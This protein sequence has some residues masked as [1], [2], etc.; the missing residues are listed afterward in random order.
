MTRYLF[1]DMW[2]VGEQIARAQA[3][4]F[5]MEFDGALAP[6]M[7]D[8][9]LISLS[10]Q[11]QRVLWSLAGQE[12]CKLAF[13]SYRSRFE[14]QMRVGLPDVW[15]VGCHGLEISGPGHVSVHPAAAVYSRQLQPVASRIEELLRPIPELS[16][17]D[18]GLTLRVSFAGLPHST[19]DPV[20]VQVRE[21]ARRLAPTCRLTVEESFLELRPSVSW[22]RASA[23]KLIQQQ[24][25]PRD[26][27][28]VYLGFDD[29]GTFLSL[30]DSITIRVD[31][32]ERSA[33]QYF[34]AGPP[35]VRRFLEWVGGL[36]RE[37]QGLL[38]S[39]ARA[40]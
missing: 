7:D 26:F 17:E 21:L 32:C 15:Y 19:I 12:K 11:M 39:G 23:I 20:I 16:C 28:P 13:F 31:E 8:D 40:L 37:H 9:A 4:L 35:D 1:D 6:P 5:C 33:A 24:L 34:V 3:V 18:R 2:S 29:E 30:D 36:G 27:L 25:A 10:P 14:L 22:N 38:V